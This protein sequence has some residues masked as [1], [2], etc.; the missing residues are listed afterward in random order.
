MDVLHLARKA[1]PGLGL[2]LSGLLLA[3]APARAAS[4]I[5]IWPINPVIE[6][7]QKAAALW[8]EN[9]GQAPVS[10]QVRVL[11]W[12]QAGYSDQLTPQQAVVGSPPVVSIAPGKRQMIRLIGLRPAPPGT[13]QAYRVLVDEMLEPDA[14]PDANLGVKFQMRYSV[15]LFVFGS[16]AGMASDAKA[17]PG[18]QPLAPQLS[19][20]LQQEGGQRFLLLH[21]Q[22]PAHARLSEVRL[23]QG[24]R[25]VPLAEGLLGYVLP[26]AR[27]RWVL[28]AG[29]ADSG[30]G[31][32]ARIN[33][34]REPRTI[35]GQ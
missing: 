10:M 30:L 23:S 5:L 33:E 4:S 9:R 15:P 18:I 22:G 31:M 6:A 28:P 12:S 35:P 8:L 2:L 1:K 3:S 24:G 13:E 16:G 7:E 34:W 26:G 32:E 27:M 11:A 21:N 17:R 29:V 20:S 19:F 14:E 25:S